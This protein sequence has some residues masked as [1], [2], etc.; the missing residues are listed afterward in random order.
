MD[1]S[2][3]VLCFVLGLV[4]HFSSAASQPGGQ[5]RCEKDDECPVGMPLCRNGV[6]SGDLCSDDKECN[7]NEWCSYRGICVGVECRTDEGCSGGRSC[8]N[9]RCVECTGPN[10]CGDNGRCENGNCVCVE[11]QRDSQCGFD[12]R[13]D[14]DSGN[15]VPFCDD[16]ATFVAADDN[17]K[18]C[19]ACVRPALD[20]PAPR[21][22]RG[23]ALCGLNKLCAQGFCIDRCN[24]RLQPPD[25]DDNRFPDLRRLRFSWPAAGGTSGCAR[26]N[27]TFELAQVRALLEVAGLERPASLRLLDP[28]G[29]PLADLGTYTPAQGSWAS[30]PPA[31]SPELAGRLKDQG[32]CGFTLEI[33]D[34]EGKGSVRRSVCLVKR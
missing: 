22:C 12:E 11:C 4:L 20:A 28:S 10:Q 15:C 9:N 23:D 33:A 18:T 2:V 17:G 19:R 5:T 13:C 6:C 30:M 25:F 3:S 21:R 26:C 14:R 16:A 29:L 24:Q 32:G 27:A 7:A 8:V 1:R 34:P 31:V